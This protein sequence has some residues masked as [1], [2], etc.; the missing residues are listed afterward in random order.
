MSDPS[1]VVIT[2]TTGAESLARALL[3]VS[4]Q[5]YKGRIKHLI[6]CDGPE[7]KSRTEAQTKDNPNI[8]FVCLPENVGKDGF[9]GHRVYAAFPHLVNEDFV[10]FLDE[11]ASYEPT[12]VETMV[13]MMIDGKYDWSYSL[14]NIVDQEGK[15]V[16]QDNCESLGEW[17]AYVG[18]ENVHLIDTSCFGFRRNFIIQVCQ[19]WHWGWGGDRRFF[20]TIWKTMG[21]TNFGTT[22]QYTVNYGLGGNP[23]SPTADFFIRGNKMM[24]TKCNG[25]FPWQTKSKPH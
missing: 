3:S 5:T 21:H 22:K 19:I 20:D 18:N 9:Y 8:S 23:N 16:C 10:F 2:P 7:F 14:R 17:P 13:N 24:E 11:D 12:H 6:V 4:R 25:T 1:V 15:F